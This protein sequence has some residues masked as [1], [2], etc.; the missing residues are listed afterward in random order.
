MY[1]VYL[2]STSADS[3]TLRITAVFFGVFNLP[4]TILVD[5]DA[6]S[7]SDPDLPFFPPPP[8]ITPNLVN[9]ETEASRFVAACVTVWVISSLLLA[10]RIWTRAV[11]L[12]KIAAEDC[13]FLL[14]FWTTF[15]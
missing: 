5:M 12:R 1:H 3:W 15:F 8:G 9:P 4:T 13:P 6:A 10:T 11:I 7:P 2:I 14:L